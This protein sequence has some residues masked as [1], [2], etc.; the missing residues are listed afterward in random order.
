MSINIKKE[1]LIILSNYF[2]LSKLNNF[3][4]ANF[5][6][7][8]NDSLINDLIKEKWRK[9]EKIIKI[10]GKTI[11]IAY[12]SEKYWIKRN[13]DFIKI[14]WNLKI[15]GKKTLIY[16]NNKWSKDQYEEINDE[17]FLKIVNWLISDD[18][19]YDINKLLEEYGYIEFQEQSINLVNNNLWDSFSNKVNNNENING[20]KYNEF[21]IKEKSI[22]LKNEIGLYE[23]KKENEEIIISSWMKSNKLES[24]IINFN[25]SLIF[26]IKSFINNDV[27][28][29]KLNTKTII[30]SIFGFA[31]LIILIASTFSFIF[32]MENINFIAGSLV[33][34]KT[35]QSVWIYLILAS[36]SFS[37]FMPFFISFIVEKIILKKE[38][39][40]FSRVSKYFIA[41]A[42]RNSATFL[43]GNFFLATFVWGW[44]LNRKLDIKV[45]TLFKTI[46]IVTI[47]RAF[48]LSIFGT[49]IMIMGGAS[50]IYMFYNDPLQ[51]TLYLFLVAWI[52]FIWQLIHNAWIYFLIAS[53][54]IRRLILNGQFRLSNYRKDYSDRAINNVYYKNERFGNAKV[55]IFGKENRTQLYRMSLVVLL[56]M[57]IEGIESIYYF[58]YVDLLAANASGNIG[59][60]S[61]YWNFFSISGIRYMGNMIH[62]FPLINILPGRGM[63]FSEIGLNSFYELIY[64]QHH[65]GKDLSG[66]YGYS[67]NDLAQMTSFITRF[68][69]VYL[70]TTL[71]LLISIIVI[72]FEIFK[73]RKHE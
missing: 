17:D 23:I 24:D 69:N 55:N 66:I 40:S 14:Y 5:E 10:D 52:G 54:F 18:F 47:M 60:Y 67:S 48:V 1:N 73:R 70:N 71:V 12:K 39:F 2:D 37:F 16:K 57:I 34:K 7:S 36:F 50:Y 26:N 33:Y 22:I 53:T 35:W 11:E 44:Y 42:L 32:N 51:E 3:S 38:R 56:P 49:L 28:I 4:L 20:I 31:I 43:T 25:D 63:F 62:H 45:A 27:Q 41:G 30:N 65:H 29:R 64:S 15:K 59:E 9:F 58:N 46:G 72:F 68:F 8:Q 19:V 61:V 13:F 6:I 21:L